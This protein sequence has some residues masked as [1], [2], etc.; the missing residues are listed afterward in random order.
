MAFRQLRLV[1]GFFALCVLCACATVEPNVPTQGSLNIKSLGV[2]SDL[3][4]N[5]YATRIGTTVFQNETW[6]TDALDL[7]ANDLAIDNVRTLIDSRT[8]AVT[9]LEIT[10][11]APETDDDVQSKLVTLAEKSNLDSVLWIKAKPQFDHEMDV[12]D[13]NVELFQRSSWDRALRCVR[14]SFSVKLIV[15]SGDVPEVYDYFPRRCLRSFPEGVAVH[16]INDQRL[17]T[18]WGI[19]ALQPELG[20]DIPKFKESFDDFTEDERTAIV[21]AFQ[22]ELSGR[23][24]TSL[25]ALTLK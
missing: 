23:L 7:N 2:Y 25:K 11:S 24:D 15:L 21:S 19:F 3:N 10:D 4:E 12:K 5:F 8:I 20:D 14:I 22:R 9:P 17:S 1:S 18:F 13:A 16:D 6:T